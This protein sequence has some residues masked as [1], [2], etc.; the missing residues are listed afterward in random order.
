[1]T[2][3]EKALERIAELESRLATAKAQL[4]RILKVSECNALAANLGHDKISELRAQL[5]TRDAEI[6]RLRE[7]ASS[8]EKAE[9]DYRLV[10]Q[11]QGVGHIETSRCWERLRKAGDAVRQYIPHPDEDAG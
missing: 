7:A 10:Y 9:H 1:M 6:E 5:A 8:L 11:S 4:A 2:V 3:E